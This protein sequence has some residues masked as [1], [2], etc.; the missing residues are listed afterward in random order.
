MD[1]NII[2]LKRIYKNKRTKELALLFTIISLLIITQTSCSSKQD[3]VSE[4]GYYLDTVCNITVYDIQS[5]DEKRAK[6]AIENAYK[7]CAKYENLLSKTREKSDIY[8]INH[9]RG[10]AVKCKTE[11]VS[12]LKKAIGY[13]ELSNGD[14]DVTIGKATD[15]WNF[16]S[17]NPKVPDSEKVQDA[18]KHVNYRNISISG[19]NVSLSDPNAEI[20]LGGIAKGFIADKVTKHLEKEGVKSA[21]INLGGNVSVIGKKGD[22]KFNIGV[23]KP[24]SNPEDVLG[25]VE[26][27]DKTVVTSGSYERYFEKDGHEYHHI[28]DP[29]TGFPKDSDLISVTVIGK[30]NK[31]VDC[32]ALATICFMAG[33]KRGKQIIKDLGGYKAIF[34]QN[35][36]TISEAGSLTIEAKFL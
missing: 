32:D 5:G 31:S 9:A 11:T 6:E 21:I 12:L 27:S 20:D 24:F 4:E 23:R 29:K 8:K 18:I 10:K 14:F 34:V 36:G 35:D 25:T 13:G 28:L 7:I 30:K 33:E 3:P 22:R 1:Y 2:M 17:E 19:D 16:H 26:V 15:L